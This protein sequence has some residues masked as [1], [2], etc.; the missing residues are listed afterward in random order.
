MSGKFKATLNQQQPAVSGAL[1][2]VTFCFSE[3]VCS[4]HNPNLS[5]CISLNT[6]QE[7]HLSEFIPSLSRP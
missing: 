2:T 4:K 7:I 3:Q 5:G 1:A 6:G